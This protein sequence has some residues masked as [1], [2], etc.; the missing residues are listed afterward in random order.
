MTHVHKDIVS[1]LQWKIKT[2]QTKQNEAK[3]FL[4]LLMLLA[5]QI[6]AFFNQKYLQ[7]IWR[8]TFKRNQISHKL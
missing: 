8:Q 6:G 5:N 1:N 2:F 7:S 3:W 4:Y